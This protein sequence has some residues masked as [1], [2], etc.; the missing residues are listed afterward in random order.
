MRPEYSLEEIQRDYKLGQEYIMTL[1][2]AGIDVPILI[3]TKKTHLSVRFY[4][5]GQ[6]TIN[7]VAH[8]DILTHIWYNITLRFGCALFI[9]GELLYKGYMKSEEDEVKLKQ[10]YEALGEIDM[11]GGYTRPYR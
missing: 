1:M 8:E 5:N 7:R 6:S 4:S 2:R 3:S 11:S 10:A 9:D